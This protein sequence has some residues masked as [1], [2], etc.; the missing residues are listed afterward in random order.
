MTIL[1][2]AT[3][4]FT[5]T[6]ILKN[7]RK[8]YTSWVKIKEDKVQYKWTGGTMT[9]N[10]SLVAKIIRDDKTEPARKPSLD[11]EPSD[12]GPVASQPIRFRKSLDE[13]P[14]KEDP[15]KSASY[16]SEEMKR[17]L[18]EKSELQVELKELE[19]Y[20]VSL[21]RSRRNTKSVKAKIDNRRENL[22]DIDNDLAKIAG[23]ARKYGISQ[24][25]VKDAFKKSDDD[26]T[27]GK[28]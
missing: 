10:K 12:A 6:I 26:G 2:F 27:E 25:N 23:D 11:I 21:I 7:G 18:V 14:E 4:S 17:L 1:L 8:I 19:N 16:W 20:R 15:K 13:L 5:D 28:K 3:L 22:K 9:I 24:K